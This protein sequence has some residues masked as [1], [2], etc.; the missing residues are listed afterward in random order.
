MK[1]NKTTGVTAGANAELLGKSM[2]VN[3]VDSRTGT[4]GFSLGVFYNTYKGWGTETGINA[5]INS[6]TAA[7][8]P[9]SGGLALTNNSQEGFDISPSFS[10]RLSKNDN[11]TQGRITIGTNYT[12]E[13]GY[14]HFKSPGK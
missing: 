8:G 7:K 12:P 11:Q 4:L 3:N 5:G 13:W 1:E 6:G 10:A 9:L 14:N 2:K